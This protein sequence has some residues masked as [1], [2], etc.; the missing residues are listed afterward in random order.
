M[1]EQLYN[2]LKQSAISAVRWGLLVILIATFFL[3]LSLLTHFNVISIFQNKDI[4]QLLFS[5]ILE[6]IT[7]IATLVVLIPYYLDYKLIKNDTYIRINA[8]V[9]RFDFYWSGCEP[10]EQIWFPVFEDMNTG[11]TLKMEVDEKVEVGDHYLIA[12]LPRTKI[13]VLKKGK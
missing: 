4:S 1:N 5:L 13:Y 9:S 7:I 6:F 11:K 2:K 10:A 3:V 12:F 8:V